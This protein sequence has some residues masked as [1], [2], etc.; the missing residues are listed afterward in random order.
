ME[1]SPG[2]A[3]AWDNYAWLLATCDDPVIRDTTRA[4]SMAKRACELTNMNDWTCLSTL[5]A[6]Y[7]EAGDFDQAARWAEKSKAVAPA[8]RQ[9]EIEQLV[10]TYDARRTAVKSSSTA[11]RNRNAERQ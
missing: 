4:V 1:I 3:R 5:A 11:V 8:E 7:A 10:R 6:A 9:N 2:F